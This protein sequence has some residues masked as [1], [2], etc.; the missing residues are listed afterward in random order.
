MDR[1][2]AYIWAYTLV[3]A[4]IETLWSVLCFLEVNLS[5]II[6]CEIQ[7]IQVLPD[8]AN[9]LQY[10]KTLQLYLQ[11]L[12]NEKK[13][14]RHHKAAPLLQVIEYMEQ[15]IKAVLDISHDKEGKGSFRYPDKTLHIL[16]YY[17]V[18]F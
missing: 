15:A 18:F 16:L 11:N 3:S 6:L 13:S 17:P 7:S 10:I 4:E 5:A 12:N 1:T 14:Q 8:T 2:R 9:V